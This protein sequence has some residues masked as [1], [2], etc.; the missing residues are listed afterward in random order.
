MKSAQ[1]KQSITVVRFKVTN[2]SNP[3]QQ[4]TWLT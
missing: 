1:E 4:L 3:L 2:K